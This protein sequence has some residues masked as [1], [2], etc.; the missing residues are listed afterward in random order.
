MA[1][2]GLSQEQIDDLLENQGAG[3]NDSSTIN[4]GSAEAAALADFERES[5][6][7]LVS[8]IVAMT[9][10]EL[11]MGDIEYAKTTQEEI[12]S[13]LGDDIVFKLPITVGEP[14]V[15]YLSFDPA[16]AKKV[17]GALTGA[18]SA[19]DAA[20][21]ALSE[22]E[23]SAFAEVVSQVN[24]AY[25]TNLAAALE[26]KT[27]S[28]AGEVVDA[29]SAEQIGEGSL[30]SSIQL[31]QKDGQ[32]VLVRHLIP[33]ELAAMIIRKINE[34]QESQE[35]DTPAQTKGS[36]G[37][38][39]AEANG[40]RDARPT[41]VTQAG[42]SSV[43]QDSVE[44]SP[45]QFGQ[46]Q[47]SPSGGEQGNLDLLLDVPLQIA[48]EL[49]KTTVPIKQILEYGQ[50]SLIALD[51]LAGE[52]IDLLVNGKYFAKG[53]VVVIDENFGVR[54]TSILSKADRLSQL[55]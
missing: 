9:G 37:V 5:L 4:I 11:T 54:I 25:L 45:A 19:E 21:T 18:E 52:P 36:A 24:G 27:S 6:N 53:E 50:G 30:V 38:S 55:G 15:H 20:E 34:P 43:V 39:P 48:V 40:G 47:P 2:V 22:M 23:R 51:K 14:M 49:G 42:A 46:L 16:F 44:Y 10:F 26:V 41:Q 17:A 13:L 3:N 12:P 33:N 1:E 28:E 29:A 31:N 7:N 32:P 8:V 35:G